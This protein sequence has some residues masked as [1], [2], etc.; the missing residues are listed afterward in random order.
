MCT[1]VIGK[2]FFG[3]IE[4]LAPLFLQGNIIN[5]RFVAMGI[6]YEYYLF[7]FMS[8]MYNVYELKMVHFCCLT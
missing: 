3:T 5:G 4:K 6:E 8:V 1:F 7:L 2:A